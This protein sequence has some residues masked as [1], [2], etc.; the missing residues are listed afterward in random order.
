MGGKVGLLY[1]ALEFLK[2]LTTEVLDLGP[3]VR[4]VDNFIQW[5]NL[6]S[7]DKNGAF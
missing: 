5:V 1:L 7:T 6:S 3:V 4:R 2:I